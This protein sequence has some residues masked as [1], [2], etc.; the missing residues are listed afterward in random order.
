MSEQSPQQ[1]FKPRVVAAA[2]LDDIDNPQYLLVGRRHANT[3]LAGFWEFPGGKVEPGETDEQALEREISEELGVKVTLAQEVQADDSREWVL[4]HGGR[5]RLFTGVVRQGA[6]TCRE[7]HDLLSWVP[8]NGEE[9]RE[10]EWIP[11]NLPIL[12]ALLS[13]IFQTGK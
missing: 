5:M 1:S 8:L 7:A 11:A 4:G 9:I 13:S 3:S 2:L 6:P 12:D 10:L